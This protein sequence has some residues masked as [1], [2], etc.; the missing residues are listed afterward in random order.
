VHWAE[1]ALGPDAQC[2]ARLMATRGMAHVCSAG[3]AHGLDRSQHVRP[4]CAALAQLGLGRAVHGSQRERACG[5]WWRTARQRCSA[6]Q[7]RHGAG[8]RET[9]A[10]RDGDERRACAAATGD[11]CGPSDAARTTAVGTAAV[12]AAARGA[13]WSGNGRARQGARSAS[14]GREAAVGHGAVKARRA[15][16]TRGARS[17]QRLKAAVPT[18]R[19][20][21][22]RQWRAAARARC[23]AGPVQRATADKRGP[24]LSDFRIKNYPEGN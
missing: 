3:A 15:V 4:A 12:G 1:I 19:V 16:V 14:G 21:A 5:A 6:S 11:G 7:R 23:C 24:L 8:A 9:A 18:R 20:A 17:R 2:G 13:R 22:T 10:R